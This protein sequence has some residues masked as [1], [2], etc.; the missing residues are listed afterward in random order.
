[1]LTIAWDVDDVLNDLMRAWFDE[2][3]KPIHSD[4]KVKYSELIEN[5]PHRVLQIEEARY[6]ESLDAFRLSVN[7]ERLTPNPDIVRWFKI[8]GHKYR[9]MVLT[10]VPRIA[11]GNSASWVF[12]HF[13][14]WIRSF[15]VV[16]SSRPDD[17]PA[18]PESTKSDYLKWLNLV[19]IFIDD[20]E[21]TIED[22]RQ[23]GINCLMPDRPW[24]SGGM[25]IHEILDRLTDKSI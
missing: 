6:L 1:M 9:H 23:S 10:A 13:G 22:V 5:P 14:D 25:S 17:I 19:D 3:W 12:T 18:A 7:F 21:K 24:N 15:H 11:A 2:W 20:N 4:C 16:P 8:H